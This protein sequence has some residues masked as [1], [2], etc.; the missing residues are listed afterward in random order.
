M[1]VMLLSFK[2]TT[3]GRIMLLGFLA[4]GERD[5]EK[6]LQ[7]HAG[8][9]PQFDAAHKAG[10]TIDQAIEIDELPEFDEDSIAE[11]CDGLFGLDGDDEAEGEDEE[12]DEEEEDDK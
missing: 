8:A 2:K 1:P 11:F 4:G 3:S 12:E 7:S 10:E 5:A 9:C 6:D